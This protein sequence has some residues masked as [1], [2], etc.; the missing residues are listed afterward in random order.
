[1]N[2]SLGVQ[3]YPFPFRDPTTDDPL[4][5]GTVTTT[6]AGTATPVATFADAALS[7]A[8]PNPVTLDSSGYALMYF[9]PLN[10]GT[11]GV[12]YDVVVKDASGT[13][14]LVFEDVSVPVPAAGGN[15]TDAVIGYGG[16]TTLTIAGGL[17]TPTKNVHL[18]TPEGGAAD[19]LDTIAVTDL[20][21][22][23]P[24][25]FSNTSASAPITVRNNIGNILTADGNSVVL[26]TTAKVMTVLRYGANWRQ[27]VNATSATGSQGNGACEGRLTL[28]SGTPVTSGD[29]SGTTLYYTPYTGNVIDLYDGI[30]AWQRYTFTELTLALSVGAGVLVDIFVYDNGGVPTLAQGTPWSNATTRALGLARQQGV[31]VLASDTTRR[32]VGTISATGTSNTVEDSLAKRYLWNYYHRVRR[33]VQV[34]ESTATWSYSTAT[35]RQANN[36]TANQIE[37]VVGV[38]EDTID[39]TLQALVFSDQPTVQMYAA[40]GLNSTTPISS[41]GKGGAEVGT[42]SIMP[43]TSR[44]CQSA[45]VGRN[46][47]WWLERGPGAGTT[48]WYGVGS[49]QT[50]SGIAGTTVG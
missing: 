30:G 4:A 10:G 16:Q 36:S 38:A 6:L 8:N 17:I 13:V 3:L 18:V 42:N 50:Q 25:I 29:V 46:A 19:N 40:I 11:A 1:M 49:G 7:A 9:S 34:L 45:S 21:D 39:L 28:T 15:T 31:L 41:I 23:A 14:R 24:L 47:Y 5:L 26:D 35:Y 20:P 43:I 48:T 33:P 22:G 37:V 27:L 44:V 32:Y 12:S 2:A